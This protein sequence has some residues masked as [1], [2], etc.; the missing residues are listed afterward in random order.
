MLGCP[1]VV[2]SEAKR[3]CLINCYACFFSQCVEDQASSN[4]QK[5]ESRERFQFLNHNN[6]VPKL[7]VK[8]HSS[9]PG[10]KWTVAFENRKQV[11]I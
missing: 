10:P 2:Y 8:L 7:T 9:N 11:S 1:G 6:T 5:V 4:G 3:K